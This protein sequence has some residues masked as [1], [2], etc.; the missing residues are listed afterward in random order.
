MKDVSCQGE[1]IC[2]LWT[3]F[4]Q[5]ERR[6]AVRTRKKGSIFSDFIWMFMDGPFIQYIQLGW[7]IFSHE[8]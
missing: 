2:P 3:I 6:E 8:A 7:M 4:G 5:G 1:G